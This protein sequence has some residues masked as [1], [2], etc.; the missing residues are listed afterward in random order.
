MNY[1]VSNASEEDKEAKKCVFMSKIE[2]QITDLRA[3]E[4]CGRVDPAKR[5]RKKGYYAA[6]AGS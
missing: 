3:D 2:M 1:Y 6:L 5:T 4:G